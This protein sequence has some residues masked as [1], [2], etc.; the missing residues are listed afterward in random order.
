MSEATSLN[1][2]QP[3]YY[4]VIFTSK[5]TPGDNGYGDTAQ[6][7]V[8][9]ASLQPGFLGVE[10]VRGNDGAGVTIS[11]W[12]DLEAINGWKNHAEHRQAQAAGRAKWYERYDVKI[13]RVE[14]AYGNSAD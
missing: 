10:S 7:M 4:A 11:Y 13:A 6:R 2:P 14:R 9:L 5:R 8:T 12:R 1:L 3:P